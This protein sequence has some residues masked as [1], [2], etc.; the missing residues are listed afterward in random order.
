MVRAG[1][2]CVGCTEAFSARAVCVREED[3]LE[4]DDPCLP[5]RG[6]GGVEKAGPFGDIQ[7]TETLF[8]CSVTPDQPV[9]AGPMV[10]VCGAAGFAPA[11]CVEKG[12]YPRGAVRSNRRNGSPLCQRSRRDSNPRY[13]SVKRFSRPSPQNG[14]RR[15]GN[16]L[17]QGPSGA[18]KPAYKRNSKTVD[19]PAPELPPDLAEVV[20]CWPDL[21]EHI[22]AAI[23]TLV[24]AHGRGRK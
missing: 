6:D 12:R 16:D 2:L 5:T 7:A 19:I 1:L 22:K 14:K 15:S 4:A 18:Y 23:T 10:H 21:P 17:E 9:A 20:T 24:Q 11:G 13:L 3:R 8:M